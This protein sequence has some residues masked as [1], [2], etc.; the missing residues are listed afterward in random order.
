MQWA[1][2]DFDEG[3]GKPGECESYIQSERLPLYTKYAQQLIEHGH[4]YVCFCSAERLELV[5]NR[6]MA[7]K[8]P[9][10]YDKSCRNLTPTQVLEKKAEQPT[11]VIRMKVPEVGELTFNDII[12]GDVTF[13]YKNVDDQVI[14]KSDGYPTYHLAVVVDDHD[15]KISHVIRG[16]EWLSSTPKHILLY[17]YFGWQAPEWAH[18]PLM[19]NPDRSKL[20]KRQGDVAVEDYRAKGYLPEA[21]V[22][23][24]A[25]L[26]WNP[27]GTREIF[28]LT[29]LVQEFSLDR[30]GK[31]GA[32]FNVEKLNWLNQQYVLK[33]P[34]DVILV[35]LRPILEDKG[36]VGLSDE[37]VK[38]IIEVLRD[39][40]T[41]IADYLIHGSEFFGAPQTY[42][43][44]FK[45]KCWKP[46]TSELVRGLC[47]ALMLVTDFDAANVEKALRDFAAEKGLGAGNLIQP[48]RLAIA[49]LGQGANLFQ[50]MVI[51]GKNEV[52][53]RINKACELFA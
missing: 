14:V 46:E 37:Y 10:A 24:I 9:P 21:L 17:Q 47:D 2:I 27:G 7:L 22:N 41:F 43:E 15:M 29:E 5:R 26:G 12:R 19:L 13:G 44:A 28:S 39:R 31:S 49:G 32:V 34:A 1:G 3:P 18:L 53:A 8:L 48:M 6:Q 50:V 4:A 51:I 38:Q 42:D 16:E 20:S 30:V 40:V 36:F 11:W 35:H 45:A 33:M 23:F 52:K 25:F